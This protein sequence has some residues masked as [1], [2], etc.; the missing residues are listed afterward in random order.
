M[1]QSLQAHL[2]QG[3]ASLFP[4]EGEGLWAQGLGFT[5][6]GILGLRGW[7]SEFRVGGFKVQGFGFRAWALR[8]SL[9]SREEM[10]AGCQ[11]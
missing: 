9:G 5:G 1:M 3:E 11:V 8:Q 2:E 10:G 7:V 4:G 6:L